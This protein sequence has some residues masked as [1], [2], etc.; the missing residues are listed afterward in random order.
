[1]HLQK[2]V[3]NCYCSERSVVQQCLNGRL[4]PFIIFS[5]EHFYFGGCL[6]IGVEQKKNFLNIMKIFLLWLTKVFQCTLPYPIPQWQVTV[7]S[8]SDFSC[9]WKEQCVILIFRM[10]SLMCKMPQGK[11][12][13]SVLI[14][15]P[16]FFFPFPKR[17]TFI[18]FS[19]YLKSIKY[20]KNT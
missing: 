7:S 20:L 11:S 1:M 16:S 14:F 10:Y 19:K 9:N 12:Q 5:Y 13:R 6:E 15:Q 8:W 4:F 3:T 2:S 17:Q 18:I